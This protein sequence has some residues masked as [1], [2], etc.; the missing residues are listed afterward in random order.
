MPETDPQLI[1]YLASF[2]TD[3]RKEKIEHILS[4]RTKHIAVVLEDIYHPYNASAIMRSCECFGI[5]DLHIIEKTFQYKPN[6]DVARGANKWTNLIYHNSTKDNTKDCINK[7]RADGYKI[8]ATAL[9]KNSIPIQELPL[10]EKVAVF[11]GT[12]DSGV[13][14]ELL[15]EADYSIIIPMRGFT[16]SFN[17]SVSLGIILYELTNRLTKSN[18]DWN[19]TGE[20]KAE[21]RLDWYKKS[22]R[23]LEHLLKRYNE[24]KN[25]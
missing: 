17:V 23:S 15:N 20:E 24:E 9:N 19:L 8:V 6:I 18:I 10:N 22:V 13:S 5:Q 7:L 12:E 25:R 1:E 4:Q 2:M 3:E 11:M 16:Q 14:D 21:L